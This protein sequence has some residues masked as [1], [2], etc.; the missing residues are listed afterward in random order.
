MAVN[1]GM[2]SFAHMHAFSYA[3]SVKANPNAHLVGISDDDPERGKN[4][5][6]QFETTYFATEEQLLEAGVDAVI[7]CTENALHRSKTEKAATAGKHIMCEKPI[8]I[9]VADAKAMIAA[10]EE[11][12]VQ[13]MTAFPCRYGP[14][15]IEAQ[16][17][18][19]NGELGKILAIK[20]TNR[21]RN[22][23]GWFVQPHLSGGG[24]T[25]DHTVHITDLMR[26]VTGAEVS[27]VYCEMDKFFNPELK[28]DD[29]GLL[30]LDFTDGCIGS[31]D[32]SWSRPINYPTWGDATMCIIGENGNVWVDLFSEKLHVYD[33]AAANYSWAA[34]GANMD[35]GL[36]ADFVDCVATGRPVPITG[37]DGMKAMEVGLAAYESAKIGN[38]VSLT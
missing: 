24:A 12:G 1:I 27:S 9:S 7:I 5:A 33:V 13:L 31:L 32:C 25:I 21:G 2:I 11:A 35:E 20:G 22:P 29:A 37:Y 34:Y 38:K 26:C 23:G 6:E 36:V 4:M 3:S 10:T 17:M 14:A 30:T 19:D 18:V 8:S 15:Y 28:C 16:R